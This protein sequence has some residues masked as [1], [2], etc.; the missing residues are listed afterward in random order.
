MF[1]MVET[2]IN[3]D[4]TNASSVIVNQIPWQFHA[5]YMALSL[6][7]AFAG[8]F[9]FLASYYEIHYLSSIASILSLVGIGAGLLLVVATGIT[10]NNI[11]SLVTA[12]KDVGVEQ[13]GSKCAFVLPQFSQEQLMQHGCSNKYLSTAAH[14]ESLRCK[15]VEI[16][17]MW[18]DNK[19]MLVQDQ[20]DMF[21]CL[22][23]MCCQQVNQ[24]IQ[25]RFDMVMVLDIFLV[26]YLLLFIM[27]LQYLGNT[28]SR[29]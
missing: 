29:Y 1:I 21:G 6:F 5:K 4:G 3:F 22:N 11:Q 20:K 27:N 28:I 16:A 7:L 9:G 12:A 10:S 8:S 18:E 26:L 24:I 13:S 2:A 14:V 23:L 17:R 15:K 19:H 25:G